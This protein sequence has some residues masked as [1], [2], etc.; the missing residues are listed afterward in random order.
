MLSL[1][2][3]TWENYNT[4]TVEPN[5][6]YKYLKTFD[7]QTGVDKFG[8]NLFRVTV[9]KSEDKKTIITAYPSQ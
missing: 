1:I 3:E 5:D 7:F 8:R 2:Q 6:R 4:L 9:I